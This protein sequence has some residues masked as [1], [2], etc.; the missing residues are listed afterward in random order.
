MVSVGA[1]LARAYM[2]HEEPQVA[3]EWA[4]RTLA[5]AERLDM[6]AEVAEAMNTKA[7]A[8]Q[9]LGRFI[10]VDDDPARGPVAGRAE[11]PHPG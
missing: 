7:L 5:A 10:E 11:R 2:L 4:E 3:L 9:I 8:L 6:V 1:Q